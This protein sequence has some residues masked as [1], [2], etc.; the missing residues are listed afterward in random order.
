MRTLQQRCDEILQYLQTHPDAGDTVDG[1]AAWW[2]TQHDAPHAH[3]SVA[4]AEQALDH[5]VQRG[6]VARHVLVEGTIF[7]TAAPPT[8]LR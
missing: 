6:L 2:L 7:Y 3:E 8:P 5:L 1:I 4:L